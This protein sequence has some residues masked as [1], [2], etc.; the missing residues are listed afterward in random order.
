MVQMLR[1]APRPNGGDAAAD[2]NRTGD[3]AAGGAGAQAPAP[4]GA[5][6]GPTP[7][8]ADELVLTRDPAYAKDEF[9][10]WFRDQVRG[11]LG[12]WGLALDDARVRMATDAGTPVVALRWDPAWGARPATRDVP[13]AMGP[14]E[15]K[16]SLTAVQRLP[17]WS[18]V[19]AA[20]RTV[21]VNLLGGETNQLSE[22]ARAHLRGQF[23]GL[24]GRTD[25]E[26]AAALRGVIGARDAS[27]ALIDEQVTTT[28]IG[29]ALQGP[30]DKPQYAF[31]GRQADAE[32]WQAQFTDGVSVEIVAPKAPEP[33][34]H[35]HS[36]QQAA[37]AASYLPKSARQVITTVLLNVVV[38][39]DDAYWAV[40]YNQP[41]FHSYMTAGA[42]GVVTIYPDTNALPNDNYMR[43]T[44]IHETGHTWSYRTWGQDTT[45]GKWVDWQ[46]A[47][48]QD[49]VSVSGYAMSS[50]AEDV[51][52]T[53]TVYVS[54][55]NTPKFDEYRSIVPNRFAMLA[56]E[57]R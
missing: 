35:Y 23:A 5:A 44:M 22:A 14:I 52:E 26:Q 1:E 30:V 57:Y 47:M 16:A 28:P 27:P 48:D 51:A 40:E 15:A 2:A 56:T 45:Q 46:R 29:F 34:F 4:Q 20:D 33:G 17:G 8:A 10:T 38:N 36:V 6:P 21:L 55:R 24:A 43:G 7:I 37:D 42:A 12:A 11:T 53:I 50:I 49:R 41:D 9:L 32:S 54:T 13:F 25:D 39:P 19:D 3:A 18:K 31:R